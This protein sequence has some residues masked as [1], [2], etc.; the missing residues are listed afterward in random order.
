MHNAVYA[1]L[2]ACLTIFCMLLGTL[3]SSTHGQ[4]LPL[5]TTP[6]LKSCS[7]IYR[8][9]MMLKLLELCRKDQYQDF[10]A[11]VVVSALVPIVTTAVVETVPTA[12]VHSIPADAAIA[13]VLAMLKAANIAL[14]LTVEASLVAAVA[15]AM[16]PTIVATV[17]T[18]FIAAIVGAV[19]TD[20]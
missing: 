1:S 10:A 16:F 2:A 20:L 9:E 4:D 19:E 13:V 12:L 8:P 11:L 18:A 5:K 7:G 15:T 3:L 6:S 17:G 14:V